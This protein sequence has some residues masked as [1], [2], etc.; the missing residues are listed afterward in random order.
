MAENHD[1]PTQRVIISQSL[2]RPDGRAALGLWLNDGTAYAIEMDP[3][4]FGIPR[5]Q[6]AQMESHLSKPT[7]SA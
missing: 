5:K 1:L 7:G 3:H 6:I 2:L 4:I